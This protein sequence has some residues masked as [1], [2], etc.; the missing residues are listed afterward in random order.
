MYRE[1]LSSVNKGR[2][3]GRQAGSNCIKTVKKIIFSS[4]GYF[5]T[6]CFFVCIKF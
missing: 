1:T 4:S 5:I 6:H 3:A 2:Q